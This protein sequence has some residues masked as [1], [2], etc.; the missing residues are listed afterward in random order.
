VDRSSFIN[1]A[2]LSMKIELKRESI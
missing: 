2:W 1:M